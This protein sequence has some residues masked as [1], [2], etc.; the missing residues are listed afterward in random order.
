MDNSDDNLFVNGELSGVNIKTETEKDEIEET[1]CLFLQPVKEENDIT[2]E[3]EVKKLNSELP[4][5][6]DP[7]HIE[8]GD[9]PS[10]PDHLSLPWLKLE[11]NNIKHEEVDLGVERIESVDENLSR[12]SPACL[13]SRSDITLEKCEETGGDNELTQQTDGSVKEF[14]CEYCEK[15]YKWRRSLMRHMH[16]HTNEQYYFPKWEQD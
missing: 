5:D 4:I 13:I 11:H 12:L 10:V 2:S 1:E 16:F 14:K 15:K 8:A 3:H 6:Q 9:V 7:L